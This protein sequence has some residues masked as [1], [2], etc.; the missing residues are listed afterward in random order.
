MFHTNALFSN[1][2]EVSDRQDRLPHFST[3]ALQR[4]RAIGIGTG[5]LTCSVYLALVRKGIG[6]LEICDPDV[7][8]LSN[9]NR[10]HFFREDLHQPKAICLARHAARH[11]LLPCQITG[12]FVAFVE[13]SADALSHDADLAICGV[14]NDKTRAIASRYFRGKQIPVVHAA[15]SEDAAYGWVFVEEPDG[16]CVGCVHHRIAGALNKPLRCI[17]SPAAIDILQTLSGLILYAADSLLMPRPRNWNYR[18]VDLRGGAPDMV[19]TA[20]I[21]RDCALCGGYRHAD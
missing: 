11:G 2:E 16:P 19:T 13:E 8:E 12:H 4:G 3:A 10:Q 6:R 7:V 17:D 9:L 5:G 15:V 21:R 1:R 18:S 20:T 14:D